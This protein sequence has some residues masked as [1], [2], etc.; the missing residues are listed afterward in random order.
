MPA[1]GVSKTNYLLKSTEWPS[2]CGLTGPKSS[3]LTAPTSWRSFKRK[4]GSDQA[5]DFSWS[6][7]ILYAFMRNPE[8]TQSHKNVVEPQMHRLALRIPSWGY[9]G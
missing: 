1:Y 7:S 8:K 9:A 3:P 5:L 6:A 4:A 2:R